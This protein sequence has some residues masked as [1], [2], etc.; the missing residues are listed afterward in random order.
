CDHRTSSGPGTFARI[1][2]RVSSSHWIAERVYRAAALDL[3]RDLKVGLLDRLAKNPAY[4]FCWS[5]TTCWRGTDETSFKKSY[6]GSRF[7]A[8]SILSAS[9][10]GTDLP[11]SR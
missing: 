11:V 10:Y 3:R 6:S 8:V 2:S 4:A 5:R 7:N 9:A 1:N